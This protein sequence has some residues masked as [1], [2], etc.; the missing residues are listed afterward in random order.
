MIVIYIAR[1]KSGGIR[2]SIKRGYINHDEGRI[3]EVSAIT[4]QE[5]KELA[6]P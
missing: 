1:L 6:Q 3:G 2:T 4:H 5:A